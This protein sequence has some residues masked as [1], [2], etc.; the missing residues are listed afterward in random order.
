M[1]PCAFEGYEAELKQLKGPNLVKEAE[2]SATVETYTLFHDRDG[3][4]QRG[5]IV[6]RLDDGA[7]FLANI[8]MDA[9]IR[10]SIVEKE[11]IGTRGRVRSR[12]G[13][14]IFEA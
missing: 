14:N 7:R 10:E 9:A 4:P 11:L 3:R 8:G 6:G 5:V 13:L 1:E 12:G 2:G